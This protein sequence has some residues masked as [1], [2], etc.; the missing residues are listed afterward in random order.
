MSDEFTIDAKHKA[1][2][3][4]AEHERYRTALEECARLSGAD[5]S[6]GV[7]TW[8]PIEEWAVRCVKELRE[9]YDEALMEEY[10]S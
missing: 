8:P 10:T 3:L 7:P 2:S 9:A 6:D 1:N 5:M 4:V